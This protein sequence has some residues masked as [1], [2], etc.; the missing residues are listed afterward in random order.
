MYKYFF[1]NEQK[2]LIDFYREVLEIP[3]IKTDVDESNGVYLGFFR[4]RT[5]SLYM[6]L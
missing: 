1:L 3:F 6:G 5:N 4:R 2:E